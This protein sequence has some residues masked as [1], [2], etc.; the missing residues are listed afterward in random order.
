MNLLPV[1]SDAARILQEQC[2]FVEFTS[3]SRDWQTQ[4]YAMAVNAVHAYRNGNSNW[5]HQVY[6]THEPMLQQWLNDNPET[7]LSDNPIEY[8]TGGLYTV[9]VELP[10]DIQN[11]FAHHARRAFDMKPPSDPEQDSMIQF[12]IKNLPNLELYLLNEGGLK[13][14]HAQFKISPTLSS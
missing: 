8:L 13:I 11:R 5:L 2:P 12:R 4:A 7:W 6:G 10:I 1:A 3:G 9:L 14:Y